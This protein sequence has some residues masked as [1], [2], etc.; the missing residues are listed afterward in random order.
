M[1]SIPFFFEKKKVPMTHFC[2]VK[3]FFSFSNRNWSYDQKVRKK[4]NIKIF[5]LV[6]CIIYLFDGF[7]IESKPNIRIVFTME[8]MMAGHLIIF[9]AFKFVTSS[10][11]VMTQYVTK[12]LFILEIGLNFNNY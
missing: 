4:K 9:V 7:K 3:V 2:L 6:Y 12:F 10:G 11:V 1:L 5:Q 8:A